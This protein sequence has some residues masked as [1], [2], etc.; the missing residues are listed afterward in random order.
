M[1]CAQTGETLDAVNKRIQRGIWREGTHVLKIEGVKER[2][3]DLAEV[4]TWARSNGKHHT[5]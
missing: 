5:R 4:S 1:Y 3:I 2:W